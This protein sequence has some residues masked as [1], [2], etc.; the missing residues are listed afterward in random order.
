L[1]DALGASANTYSG[2][3]GT[4]VE[5]GTLVVKDASSLGGATSTLPLT[6]QDRGTVKFDVAGDVSY[7]GKLLLKDQATVNVASTRKLSLTGAA[8]LELAAGAQAVLASGTLDNGDA[9]VAG[10]GTI[11]L[12]TGAT[13]IARYGN[14]AEQQPNLFKVRD[15][16]TLDFRTMTPVAGS[17]NVQDAALGRMYPGATI[18]FEGVGMT[19]TEWVTLAGHPGL[20][21]DVDA[22][23]IAL[24]GSGAGSAAYS[25]PTY[26]YKLDVASGF[27]SVDLWDSDAANNGDMMTAVTTGVCGKVLRPAAYIEKTGAGLLNVYQAYAPTSTDTRIL[28]WVV[29]GGTLAA[30]T[31]GNSL[32]ATAAGWFDSGKSPF[33][34]RQHLEYL[35]VK[36]GATLAWRGTQGFLPAATY[37]GLPEESGDGWTPDDFIIHGGATLKSNG[38]PL[39]L[40]YTDPATGTNYLAYPTLK[41]AGDTDV[42]V[43]T[44]GGDINFRSG[45]KMDTKWTSGKADVNVTA[46][47]NVK[48]TRDLETGVGGIDVDNNAPSMDMIRNLDVGTGGTATIY[49][50][51]TNLEQTTLTGSTLALDPGTGNTITYAGAVS[52]TGGTLRAL[53]G[54]TNLGAT[55]VAGPTIPGGQKVAD[56]ANRWSFSE[57]G[58]AGTTLVD[59]VGGKNGTIAEL[60]ANN[61][62]VGQTYPGQAYMT[63]GAR[64]S[65]DYVSLP[66]GLVSALT[67]ATLEFW[68]T[69]HSVQNHS[70]VFEFCQDTNNRLYMRWTNGTDYNTANNALK[71]GGTSTQFGANMA[72]YTLDQEFHIVLMIDDDGGPNGETQIKVFK[73]GVL[74]DTVNTNFNLAQIPDINCNLG[75]GADQNSAN[76]SWNEFR[77][78]NYELTDA[79]IAASSAS[80]PDVLGLIPYD[81][82]YSSIFVENGAELKLGGFS[83]GMDATVLGTLNAGTG[84]ADARSITVGAA[85]APGSFTAGATTADSLNVISGT[86]TVGSFA[87]VGTNRKV[88]V[89]WPGTLNITGAG[90]MSNVAS[91]EVLG[92]VAASSGPVHGGATTVGSFPATGGG[93]PGSLTAKGGSADS[94]AVKNG[95]ADYGTSALNVTGAITIGTSPISLVPPLIINA[96]F[97]QRQLADDAYDWMLKGEGWG[98]YGQ[99]DIGIWNPLAAAYPATPNGAPEGNMIGFVGGPT[100]PVAGGF[101]QILPATLLTANVQYTLLVD[102]G[103]YGE[104]PD[105]A[106]FP[107]Y[108]IELLAG[109]TQG[110]PGTT[111]PGQVTGG[112]LLVADNN[113]TPPAESAFATVTLSYTAGASDPLL[114]Q[115]L[116]I[117][118]INLAAAPGD[119]VE[120][121]NVRLLF[122][123]PGPI[124]GAGTLIAGNTTAN[125]L[126]LIN[127]SATVGSLTGVGTTPAATVNAGTTLTAGGLMSNWT[128]LTVEG[129]LAGAGSATI[130][131]GETLAG[132][133]SVTLA[134]GVTVDAGGTVSP[135]ASAGKLT[136]ASMI[137]AGL[138]SYLW[139]TGN[140]T[141]TPGVDWDLLTVTGALDITATGTDKF[142]IKVASLGADP[143]PGWGDGSGVFTWRIAETGGVTGFDAGKFT[144][145]TSGW[146]TG[147][148]PLTGVFQ[149][150]VD[151]N[152]NL[153][154][155]YIHPALFYIWRQNAG[156]DEWQVATNWETNAVPPADKT[157]IFNNPPAGDKMPTLYASDP[158]QAVLGLDFQQAGWTLKG[159]TETLSVGTGGITSTSLVADTSNTIQPAIAFTGS[160]AITVTGAT[161]TLNTGA[162]NATGFTLTK[163]G[164]GTLAAGAVTAGTLQ[165]DAGTLIA[166]AVQANVFNV[167]AS[168]TIASLT[169]IG[170]SPSATV[171][172]GQQLSVGAGA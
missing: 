40:G 32:G 58:G 166:G 5:A 17:P 49:N 19:S 131:S 167:N 149:I 77:I 67:D 114:G 7:L 134:G 103:N 113:L 9:A 78:Y 126:N 172:A 161:H 105:Y 15:G 82:V 89:A 48:F 23:E 47:S 152:N 71:I 107:G 122:T 24:H 145:N 79:A 93:V 162:L 57:V 16:A 42:P 94:L 115:P 163:S 98:W 33:I 38:A 118:L 34:A 154:L 128:T 63:G 11:D 170:V 119:E 72:P 68:A 45:I 124:A 133:G 86:A 164:L 158:G 76:A 1:P 111:N 14:A 8:K 156:T 108:R 160:A 6:V 146:N 144:Y 26:T 120:F 165:H 69:Q 39:V 70:T 2:A 121:D 95:K 52:L 83:G 84:P 96:G 53:S 155:S 143:L 148:N 147:L 140:T 37:G 20:V 74:K 100:P 137:W 85:A 12:Q 46:G 35:E 153:M 117:R 44:L 61:A 13:L 139:E 171:A 106:G 64:A 80:G 59:S 54:T 109:G 51:H 104:L 50:S 112:T 102:V 90:G 4:I 66:A 21:F 125:V 87:G 29:S 151:I 132:S 138:G 150:G 81:A 43:I 41:G 56:P 97:E 157:A 169:G 30:A 18:K 73:D 62:D 36:S 75:R 123:A 101:A 129:T 25:S 168:A 127:G 92:T 91:L 116:Q 130:G 55:V 3:A 60:G 27:R 136:V 142:I 141:G 88:S 99:D 110:P 31:D 10:S 22:A 159:A 65:S 135:G 28:G